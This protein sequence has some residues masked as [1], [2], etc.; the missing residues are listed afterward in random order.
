M[1]ATLLLSLGRLAVPAP[2]ISTAA[3]V[4]LPPFEIAPGVLMPAVSLGHPDDEGKETASAELWLK[5]GGTGIDTAFDYRNQGEVG[6]AVKSVIASGITNRSSIFITTKISPSDCTEAAALKAVKTD[7]EQIG[8]AQVDLVLHHFPCKSV[9]ESNAIWKG[10]VAAKQQG[11]TRAIGV[12][13]YKPSDL[14]AVLSLG[15]GTPSVNQCS[16]SIGN[17][18][19]TTIA[20]CKSHKI[21]YEAYSPLRRVNLGDPKIEAIGAK[22][23]ATTAQVALRWIT[24]Q[25]IPVASSP[26]V[27]EAYCIEDLNLGAF[28]LTAAEMAALSAI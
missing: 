9:A 27:N 16:M 20:F 6:A 28:T 18:D 24:Q 23:N 3:P 8:V 15:M 1:L 14:T 17:H 21:F 4:Q 10:L 26:G 12:S 11:L 25:G 2:S 13:N 5:L 7:L 22:H 19:D